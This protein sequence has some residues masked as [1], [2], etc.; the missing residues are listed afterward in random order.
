M[1]A[2]IDR[3]RFLATATTTGAALTVASTAAA[4][5]KET[6]A[7]LG[8][9][10]VRREPFPSWPRTDARDEKAMLDV[11]RSGNWYRG[12]G[13]EVGRFESAYAELTGA[14]HC[15]ATANGTSALF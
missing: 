5:E 9:T 8:G 10:P 12:S 4:R 7:L 15:V 1:K 6:P 3:R 14:K 11:L 13:I 2:P